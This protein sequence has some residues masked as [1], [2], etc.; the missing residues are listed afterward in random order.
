MIDYISSETFGW[1]RIIQIISLPNNRKMDAIYKNDDGSFCK[2]PI[3]C[4][5]IIEWV[6]SPILLNGS[7]GSIAELIEKHSDSLEFNTTLLPLVVDFEGGASEIPQDDKTHI[8]YEIDG[9]FLDN[10]L[11]GFNVTE[12]ENKD[13]LANMY[14]EKP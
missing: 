10:N 7:K 12:E 5:G 13:I 6:D 14:K 2:M 9:K 1:Y 11:F 4:M 8:G 3:F